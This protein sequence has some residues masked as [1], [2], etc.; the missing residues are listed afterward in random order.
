MFYDEI[1]THI[2]T[3]PIQVT[4]CFYPCGLQ[5]SGHPVCHVH[6]FVV[7]PTGIDT[8]LDQR[9]DNS[10]RTREFYTTILMPKN[11]C[12]PKLKNCEMA[13]VTIHSLSVISVGLVA[14]YDR[15]QCND[16][17]TDIWGIEI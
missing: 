5:E 4:R 17:Q 6:Q 16:W 15:L 9:P 13:E 10:F 3:N 11:W 7:D 2:Q 8:W 14:V 1:L 12:L